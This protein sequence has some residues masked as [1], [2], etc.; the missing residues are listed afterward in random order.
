MYKIVVILSILSLS[1]ALVEREYLPRVKESKAGVLYTIEGIVLPAEKKLNLPKT[2]VRDIT[3]SINNGELKGFVR[4][5]RRFSISGVPSGSH[6]LQIEHPDIHFQPVIVEI[7][8][9]GKYRA[10]KVNYVQPSVVVQV[11]YPLRLLPLHR[12]KFF[13]NRE[14]WH[15]VDLILNPMVLVMVLPLL[16]MLAIPRII[17][18]PEA[19]KELESIQLP[20]IKDLPDFSDM[21]VSFLSGQRPPDPEVK[22]V[23][24]KASKK[25]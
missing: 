7:N 8:A 19:K 15:V 11:P 22:E 21:L 9:R 13:R 1:S 18:D 25:N 20:K 23:A 3:V 17:K 4:L 12:R 5:D 16:L 24:K 10:R 14:Q 2:W 6:V